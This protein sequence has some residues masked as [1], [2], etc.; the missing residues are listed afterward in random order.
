MRVKED[1]MYPSSGTPSMARNYCPGCEPD[2]DPLK[3]VLDVRWCET[4]A[5]A[6]DGTDDASVRSNS[7]LSGSSEAGG[8]AN[9][10]W[11]GVLHRD[12]KSR[13]KE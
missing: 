7:Y 4:H 8:D 11:C 1:T 2:A 5:P 9:R 3:E 10:S 12:S 13:T 6:R